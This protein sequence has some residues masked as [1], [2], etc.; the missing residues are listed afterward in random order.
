MPNNN[1]IE[2]TPETFRDMK[3]C[4]DDAI[5]RLQGDTSKDIPATDILNDN[6]WNPIDTLNGYFGTIEG[7]ITSTYKDDGRKKAQNIL[8]HSFEVLVAT[9]KEK[10]PHLTEKYESVIK[11]RLYSVSHISD[12]ITYVSQARQKLDGI[13]VFDQPATNRL[14]DDSWDPLDQL[15]L[16]IDSV[17]EVL[18]TNYVS[19]EKS[20]LQLKLIRECNCLIKSAQ[21]KNS[22]MAD[23]YSEKL[24]WNYIKTEKKYSSLFSDISDKL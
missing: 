13:S 4:I 11:P 2:F 22:Y 7:I 24:K 17:S 18:Q 10:A 3:I 23:Q 20:L 16:S 19:P 14:K 9:A 8:R 5:Y 1:S 15:A 21:K 12:L 6:D